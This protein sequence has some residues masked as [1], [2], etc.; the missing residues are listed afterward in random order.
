M[1]ATTHGLV[2][3]DSD[4]C[5]SLRRRILFHQVCIRRRYFREHLEPGQARRNVLTQRVSNSAR[6]KA[7]HLHPLV[8]YA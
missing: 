3:R 6:I 1:P 7:A 8:Y 2:I 4:P 5:L